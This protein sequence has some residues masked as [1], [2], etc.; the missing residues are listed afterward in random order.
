[1]AC[2]GIALTAGIV[3]ETIVTG[4]GPRAFRRELSPAGMGAP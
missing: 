4:Y 1:V 3:T 2:A